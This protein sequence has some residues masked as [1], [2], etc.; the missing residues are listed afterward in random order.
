M[1]FGLPAAAL[2]MYHTARPERRRAVGGLLASIALTS[3]LTGVTEP[4]EFTF[5]FLAPALYAMH[6]VLTGLAFVIMNALDVRL[7]FGFSAGLF[8]Y[9]LNFNKATRPWLLLPVGLVY[10]ALYY[11]VF[12]YFIV[13]LDLKT[14]GREDETVPVESAVADAAP[15][16]RAV[17]YIEALGGPANLVTIDACATRLRLTIASQSVVNADQLKR[18]GAR[19]VV[20]PSETALQ[21]VIGP[22]ADMI[23][24]EMRAVLRTSN[25]SPVRGAVGAAPA[26]TGAGNASV[27]VVSTTVG[28]APAA[29]SDAPGTASAPA[30]AVLTSLLSALGGHANVRAVETASTR[31]RINVTDASKV[32]EDAINS[33]GLRGLARAAPNWMHV[34]IGPGAAAAGASMRELLV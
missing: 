25:A 26:T 9:V 34:I 20:R 16:G 4:I 13:R 12:R 19:G 31:L 30:S 32:D 23:A 11:G 17:A 7:G 2:A 5:M 18:L 22:E 15:E 28:A 27:N 10:F 33:L 1:M 3:L 14:P 8:D 21:V 24:G 29:I 6:A